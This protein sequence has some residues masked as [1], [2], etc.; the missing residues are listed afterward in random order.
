MTRL[1][2][3]AL[4]L[5][6]LSCQDGPG[7][8]GPD[9]DP[10]S[11]PGLYSRTILSGDLERSY[12]L[13][14]PASWR[15]GTDLP[16][17]L[18]FHG[19]GSDPA[20]L[21]TV[22]GL[23]AVAD[24]LDFLVAYPAAATGDWNTECLECGSNAVVDEI[25]DLGLVSDL[26]DR[27][28]ADVGVDRRRVYAV[29]ISN[30]ALFVHYLACAA[31]GTITAVASVAAT[32]LAPEH[33][34]ACDDDRPVPIALFLGSDD[35]FFP[36]EG[37]LAGNDIVH[38]RLLSIDESV[39]TWAAR[40]GCDE[41]PAMTDLPDLEDDGTTVRRERYSGCDGG[42]EVVYYA[43]QGGGHTWPGSGVASGG[44]VGRTS[45]E[46][47]ASETAARFFLEHIR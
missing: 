31:Q 10:V 13:H 23:G 1:A 28:D 41:G 21:R 11:G 29:G 18:A 16:L 5:A 46:I 35:T 32:L 39:A 19:V 17:V 34:P 30:G 8:V 26:V 44:L 37:K 40:D 4:A 33:V 27:I 38:V 24:E 25:D 45:R 3:S 7:P 42:A 9:P 43:I 2:L 15:A 20:N 14:V 22:A 12:L 6:A 47:S 36:P